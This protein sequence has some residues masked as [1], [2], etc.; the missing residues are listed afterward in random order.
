M[1]EQASVDTI[2]H[3]EIC[4]R[5]PHE[6]PDQARLA[7]QVLDDVDGILQV[8]ARGPELL[9]VSYDVSRVS[10]QLIEALLAELGFHLDNHLLNKLRRALYYYSEEVQQAQLNCQ[11]GRGNCTQA[12]FINRYR[13]LPHGCRDQ[14]PEYWRR[15][16]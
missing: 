16:L 13:Q 9:A 2:K 8:S 11:R 4:F 5:G 6:H 15:Y 12:V 7:M 10:L 14:R 3:R 1:D